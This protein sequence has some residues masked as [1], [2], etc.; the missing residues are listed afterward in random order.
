MVKRKFTTP[1]SSGPQGSMTYQAKRAKT[2][3]VKR[4]YIKPGVGRMAVNRRTIMQQCA[5]K[6]K[7][8]MP[9]N[10]FPPVMKTTMSYPVTSALYAPAASSGV[11]LVALND[12]YDFD[13]SNNLGNTQPLFYDQ[14]LS[15][16]G[17][18]T[19]Y[20]V[21]AWRVKFTIDNFS[22]FTS[23]TNACA[24]DVGLAQ[25]STISTDVDTWTELQSSPNL[26]RRLLQW[27][28]TSLSRC[29][30]EINGTPQEFVTGDVKDDTL[31]GAYNGSPSQR[32]YGALGIANPN[33]AGVNVQ[34]YISVQVEQDVELFGQDAISSA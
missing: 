24:L 6:L 28:G 32:I 22:Q 11:T 14:V 8:P 9:I 30:L 18:Y 15:A 25:G 29:V 27:Y 3:Y 31:C 33:I 4:S 16:T 34:A 17:P 7:I 5:R 2:Q 1:G 26:Q 20:R 10:P 12:I 21:T 19:K 13:V 23:G